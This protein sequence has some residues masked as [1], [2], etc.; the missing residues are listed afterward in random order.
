MVASPVIA[1]G[2][3]GKRQPNNEICGMMDEGWLWLRQVL[4]AL[5]VSFR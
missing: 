2:S 5:S 3:T 1:S 4:S